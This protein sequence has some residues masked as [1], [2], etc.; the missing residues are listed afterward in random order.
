MLWTSNTTRNLMYSSRSARGTLCSNWPHAEREEYV[1]LVPLKHNLLFLAI[2]LFLLVAGRMPPCS[3]IRAA[4]GTWRPARKCSPRGTSSA[5][6]LSASPGPAS[7]G[8]TI[9]GWPNAAWPPCIAL[10]GWDGLLLLTATVL[11][12]IYTWVALRLLHSGLAWLPAGVL[13][14]LLLLIGSPQ[15]H[16]R[17]LVVT[18]GLLGVT[19]AWLVDVEAGRK[20]LRR[21]WWL[22]PLVVRVGECS[23]RRAGRPGNGR[24]L[25]RRLVPR[26]HFPPRAITAPIDDPAAGSRTGNRR[27]TARPA[28]GHGGGNALESLRAGIAP[29]V[30]ANPRPAAA[31]DHRRTST[32]RR[33]RTRRLGDTAFDGHLSDRAGG[34]FSAAATG[35]LAHAAG[36]VRAGVWGGS[37]MPPCWPW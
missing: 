18:L 15:F 26:G 1:L 9:N 35:Y 5:P 23:W 31:D 16:V 10:A 2:W 25:R 6:I 34:R 14:A 21:L 24:L 30:A 4:S 29:G 7:P 20:P 33:D 19:F 17:P 27:R 3:A 37:A 13:L 11:A 12:A 8:W 28:G 22:V 36:L 32:A